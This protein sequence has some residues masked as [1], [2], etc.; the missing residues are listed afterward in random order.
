MRQKSQ[1]IILQKLEKLN[2]LDVV[3]TK[4]DNLKITVCNLSA[5][6]DSLSGNVRYNTENISA[7]RQH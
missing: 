7:L 3:V 2:L 6:V 4:L 1:D 5:A